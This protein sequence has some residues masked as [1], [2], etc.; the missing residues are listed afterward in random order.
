MQVQVTDFQ[1]LDQV[2]LRLG[3]RRGFWAKTLLCQGKSLF[4]DLCPGA[5]LLT[6]RRQRQQL[7]ILL[8]LLPGRHIALH[9]VFQTGCICWQPLASPPSS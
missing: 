9:C 6:L 1:P 8:H 5:Y 2:I 4:C 7:Q 3:C